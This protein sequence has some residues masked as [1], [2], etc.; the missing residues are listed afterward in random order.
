MHLYITTPLIHSS[1]REITD[2]DLIH[3]L[4]RVMR[5]RIWDD[6]MI[7]TDD[8]RTHCRIQQ[9]EK[10][11][12]RLSPLNNSDRPDTNA[13]IIRAAIALPNNRTKAELIVQK[14]SEIGVD[15]ITW[16]KARRSVCTHL[17]ANKLARMHVIAKEATEQSRNRQI[18]TIS[19]STRDDLVTNSSTQLIR[20]DHQNNSTWHHSQTQKPS[21]TSEHYTIIIWPEGG[22][23][24]EEKTH[25]RTI[26]D[27][28]CL[29]PSVLRME[30]AAIVGCWYVK[31]LSWNE[32]WVWLQ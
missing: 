26:A 8:R 3:Q 13:R 10:S 19:S 12:I 28:I 4:T 22:F 2:T 29:G 20:C 6:I 9:I 32:G 31:N 25:L 16:R 18:P 24:D 15:E 30:T 11:G 27:G 14:L 1:Y 17:P 7:Q 21:S 5:H 23:D